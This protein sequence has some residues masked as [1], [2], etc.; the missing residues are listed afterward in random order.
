MRGRRLTVRVEGGRPLKAALVE[1]FGPPID[2]GGLRFGI[3]ARGA[4]TVTFHDPTFVP[5]Q[6]R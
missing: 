4:R 6:G 5:L 2:R 3:T 1:A